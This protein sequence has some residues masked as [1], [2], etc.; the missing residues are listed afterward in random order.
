MKIRGRRLIAMAGWCGTR[1]VNALSTTLRFDHASVG[2]FPVDPAAAPHDRR[3]IY[4][5]WH[6]YFLIPIVRLGDPSVAA[7]VSQH[8]DGQM[9][10]SLVRATG[11]GVVYGS[12]RRGG[13]AAVRQLLR[14]DPGH[15]H[16][17][18]TPD[19]PRGPRREVQPGVVYLA[20]RTGMQIVPLGIG[21]QNPWR[22]N[23]WDSFGI[24]RPF[25]RVRCLFGEP[26]HIPPELETEDQE[27]YQKRLQMELNKLSFS[28]ESWA[29]TGILNIP[30][31]NQSHLKDHLVQQPQRTL[32]VEV[33]VG[34]ECGD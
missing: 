1:L 12:T 29:N 27:T 2:P 11:M 15:R 14:D 26:V 10:G 4:A 6:E 23:S 13:I 31:K 34:R 9:L 21:Y 5:L 17:A 24:P 3:F 19:G 8:S 28:A 25:S 32:P 7:L 30:Q 22:V 33:G 16:L 20:S 18:V